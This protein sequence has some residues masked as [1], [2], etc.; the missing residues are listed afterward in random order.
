[1][2][3]ELEKREILL[4]S[5]TNEVEI[6]EFYLG[7]QSF[8]IN[9]HKLREIVPYE[10]EAMTSLPESGPSMKGM[11]LLRGKTVP[12]VDLGS[13]LR[14]RQVENSVERKVVLV[15]EFNREVN[16]FLV[17]G[18]NQIHRISW[19]DVKPLDDFFTPYKPRF[20]GC[21]TV[22][23][24]EVMIVDLEHVITEIFPEQTI[25]GEGEV[26]GAEEADA[27]KRGSRQEVKILVAEDSNIIRNQIVSILKSSGYEQ[28]TSFVN[29]EECWN[30]LNM[31]KAEAAHKGQD[32]REYA[33]LLISDIEMPSMDGLTLCKKIKTDPVMKEL[34]VIMFSSLINE[35]LAHKCQE[36]GADGHISKPQIHALVK[37]LDEY[38]LK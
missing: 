22:D 26:E 21:I 20:T 17:D 9:V 5:G 35:Q 3:S 23:G 19:K 24:R 29:G 4:E 30:G 36:V 25:F 27:F 28:V 15:C 16:S 10:P 2:K 11:L 34:T 32:L 13:H 33:D 6:I 37:M 8:G 7:G 14:K 1:M 38:C 12:L 31:L 18:V